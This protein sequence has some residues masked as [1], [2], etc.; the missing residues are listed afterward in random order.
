M[1]EALSKAPHVNGVLETSLYRGKRSPLC[2]IY[3]GAYSGLT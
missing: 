2:E 3:A 1:P